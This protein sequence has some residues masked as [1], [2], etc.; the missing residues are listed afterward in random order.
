MSVLERTLRSFLEQKSAGEPSSTPVLDHMK[1]LFE[2]VTGR[3]LGQTDA[4]ADPG[5]KA[6]LRTVEKIALRAKLRLAKHR[7]ESFERELDKR[8]P[9]GEEKARTMP[10]V[11]NVELAAVEDD[12]DFRNF[13]QSASA[14]RLEQLLES[15]KL[16]G[17][18]VPILVIEALGG[19]FK[20][21]A[22]FRR[23]ACARQL[24]WKSIPALVM[25]A[26][27]P[28][29]DEY[30]TNIV[31]N[32]ARD[33]LTSYEIANAAQI[34]RD[35]FKVSPR[36]FAARAGYSESYV[37]KLIRCVDKLPDEILEQWK[38]GA[39]VS[40]ETLYDF[41]NMT[42]HE[43]ISN[44]RRFIGMKPQRS[45]EEKLRIAGQS[46]KIAKGRVL[47]RMQR[48]YL[49]F[50]ENTKLELRTRQLCISVIEFCMGSRDSI[51]GIYHPR[52][53]KRDKE[54]EER[55]RMLKLPGLPEQG[56]E[57]NQMPVEED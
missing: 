56:E 18:K 39:R 28:I 33:N 29:V 23:V 40:V 46:E 3:K 2:R 4:P 22:G 19:G 48:L 47:E 20:V 13:R 14:E 45:L 11:V 24:G 30:W 32:S 6:A 31:E 9:R 38:T 54:K 41:A 57:N 1:V 25:R 42:P 55:K 36:E 52:A 17:L 16:E 37:W 15:M 43:A 10:N 50:E 34:M 27:T 44:F 51:L 26:D 8:G 7:R 12:K 35:E 21:R 53:G 5:N 49:A